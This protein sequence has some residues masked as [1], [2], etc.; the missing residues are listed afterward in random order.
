M[1]LKK[2]VKARPDMGEV[3]EILRAIQTDS[4][5]AAA[6]IAGSMID[7]ILKGAIKFRMPTKLTADEE[8]EMFSGT[9]PLSTFS[10]RIAMAYALN[11]IGRK[12]R[13]DLLLLKE[14]RNAFAHTLRHLTFD[15]PEL[16]KRCR[17][18]HCARD[19]A[20]YQT[21]PA[22]SLFT[23][24]VDLLSLYLITKIGPFPTPTSQLV[25]AGNTQL[26]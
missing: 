1:T 8:D 21:V 2:F 13:H 10:S 26:D 12:T 24:V 25:L 15:T 4:P 17:E 19:V 7:D 18:F 6:M 23:A 20:E 5:R 16:E 22:R 3:E 11:V 9:G 14:I